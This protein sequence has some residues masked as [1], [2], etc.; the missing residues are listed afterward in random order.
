MLL[1][2]Q[3]IEKIEKEFEYYGKCT[4]QV[5]HCNFYF[6]ALLVF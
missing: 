6:V 5:T 1:E 3:N 4:G 2:K